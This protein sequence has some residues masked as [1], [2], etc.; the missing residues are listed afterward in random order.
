MSLQSVG[1]Y[2][3]ALFIGV[4]CVDTEC[5]Y[6]VEVTMNDVIANDYSETNEILPPSYVYVDEW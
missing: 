6:E 4:A 3:C 1:N 5:I 2:F